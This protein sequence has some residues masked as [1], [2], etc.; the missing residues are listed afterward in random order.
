MERGRGRPRSWPRRRR[1]KI[2][3]RGR[4]TIN[5]PPLTGFG[6]VAADGWPRFTS[7]RRRISWLRRDLRRLTPG[8]NRSEQR[9]QRALSPLSLLTPVHRR[10]AELCVT[11]RVSVSQF[12]YEVPGG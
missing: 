11:G 4:A 12:S 1:N 7:V 9:E 2:I 5:R 6:A 10:A 3:F 8:F